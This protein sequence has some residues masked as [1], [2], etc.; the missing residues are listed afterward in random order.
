M[1]VV[2]NELDVVVEPRPEPP[3][4]PPPAPSPGVTALDVD[5]VVRRRAD[6]LAR[7]RAD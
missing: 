7:V 2:I 6:R 5:D 1:P 4:A 3:P